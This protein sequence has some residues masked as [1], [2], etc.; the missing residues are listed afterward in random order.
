MPDPTPQIVELSN[1]F[2]V[3]LL[4]RERRA[5]TAMVR[6]YGESWRRLQGD[7]RT[8]QTEHF[9]RLQAGEEITRGQMWRL[10]RMQA[11]QSQVEQ[12]L[13]KFGPFAAD[14][15]SAGQRE[16]I[17]SGQRNA[18]DLIQAGFLPEIGIDVSFATMPRAAVEQ[19]VGFL[20]DGSPLNDVIAKYTTDA[21]GRF[22][23]TFVTGL[24]S[25]WNPQKLA[26]E[27]RGAFG[28]G[29]TESLR[30]A[31][32][33]QLRAYR[34]AAANTYRANSHV[35]K[36]WERH[37]EHGVRTCLA[38]LVL[39]GTRYKL[40][41]E[42]DDHVQGR[43][44]MLPVTYS[45]KELGI[46][47]P[48]PDF[49]REKGID[50]FQRQSEADQIAIMGPGMY[51]A[52]KDGKFALEDV[53]KVIKSDVWGNSW[54]PKSLRQLTL[55]SEGITFE[56]P[57]EPT[58][59]R[60]ITQA[61]LDMQAE[62]AET[63]AYY[64]QSKDIGVKGYL[65]SLQESLDAERGINAALWEQF[66]L[67]PDQAGDDD[68][69]RLADFLEA[70]GYRQYQKY[71][72]T[73]ITLRVQEMRGA[74][75]SGYMQVGGKT[76]LVKQGAFSVRQG[77]RIAGQLWAEG[78]EEMRVAA[79]D[80]LKR[81]GFTDSDIAEASFEQRIRLLEELGKKQVLTTKAG[82]TSRIDLVP[83]GARARV[84]EVLDYD[85]AATCEAS[86]TDPLSMPTIDAYRSMELADRVRT[87]IL[88]Y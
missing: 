75:E 87:T 15:I 50:W 81:A 27:L 20:A 70:E 74:K 35:V 41:E 24:V 5:A 44:A 84:V 51:Q 76:I 42:M 48:E 62:I 17:E 86:A 10:E 63:L 78:K 60:P 52:W 25:G 54:V 37:A 58:I 11:I 18:Y 85:L 45:Y 57:S 36:E 43:C 40:S 34:T 19:M 80:L 4:A 26:R 66:G 13:A 14:T 67:T 32:T 28:M 9:E 79:G 2:R 88:G 39:D 68:W 59:P 7:I 30:L 71:T 31:R 3:Q 12:E 22:G 46:D 16:G 6:Y 61:E 56:G 53:P 49:S 82:K 47:A 29:L 21:G 8:L 69:A 77:Q 64:E 72:K 83:E 73:G 33:E 65:D 23:E 1:Q 55:E 38:C